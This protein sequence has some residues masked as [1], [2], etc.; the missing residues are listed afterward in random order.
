MARTPCAQLLVVRDGSSM[1]RWA[2]ARLEPLH[3]DPPAAQAAAL[4]PLAAMDARARDAL[5]ARFHPTDDLS[6]AQWCARV[7]LDVPPRAGPLQRAPDL[8]AAAGE[9]ERAASAAAGAPSG[10]RAAPPYRTPRAQAPPTRRAADAA[11]AAGSG[12][13]AIAGGGG[14]AVEDV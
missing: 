14:G 6:L 13:R 1:A 5:S 4:P 9:A 10:G 12:G 7:R 11:A 3:N 2:L 8:T